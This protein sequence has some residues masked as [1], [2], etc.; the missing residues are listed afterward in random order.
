LNSHYPESPLVSPTL[1]YSHNFDAFGTHSQNI[2]QHNG[3]EHVIQSRNNS[4]V[5]RLFNHNFVRIDSMP[6]IV[7]IDNSI[8]S[9]H[10]YIRTPPPK[11][12]DVMK[13]NH[14]PNYKDAIQLQKHLKH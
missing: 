11:Y 12:E 4:P 6:G 10:D 9:I 5:I 2:L 3:N 8:D 13:V 7:S 14:L 1:E